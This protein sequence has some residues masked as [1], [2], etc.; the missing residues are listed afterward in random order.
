M[1]T[2]DDCIALCDLT[3]EEVEAIAEHEHI[4]EMLA[5]ELGAYLVHTET[6]EKRIKRM[7]AED[8]ENATLRG[9]LKHAAQ[10]KL[11]LKHFLDAHVAA[12]EPA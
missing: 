12:A 8:I 6:G 10:L 2:I 1:L 3:P 4:P 5:A 9:D 11:V 7:I